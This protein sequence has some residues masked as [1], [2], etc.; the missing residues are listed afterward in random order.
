MDEGGGPWA[1]WAMRR[2]CGTGRSSWGMTVV[3]E[4]EGC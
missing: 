3:E 2:G 1:P 4:E